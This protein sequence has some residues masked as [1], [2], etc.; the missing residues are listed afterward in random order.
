MV[1][2]IVAVNSQRTFSLDDTDAFKIVQFTNLYIGP[3]DTN[4][5]LTM[6]LVQNVIDEESPVDLVVLTGDTVDPAF[7]DSFTDRFTDA[8]AYLSIQGI[9]WVST[10][11]VDKPGSAITRSYKL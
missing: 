11:G 5:E 9:P 4:Y 10:G 8:I 6:Q 1:V 2:G 7:E 3:G